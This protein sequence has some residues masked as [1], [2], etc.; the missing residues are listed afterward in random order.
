MAVVRPVHTVDGAAAR[1][2]STQGREVVPAQLADVAAVGRQPASAGV[3]GHRGDSAIAHAM[4]G[5]F[6]R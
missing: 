6:V 1:I 5:K 3:T 2:T 4:V